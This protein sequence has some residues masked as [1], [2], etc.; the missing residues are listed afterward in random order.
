MNDNVK[1]NGWFGTNKSNSIK[2]SKAFQIKNQKI[3]LIKFE[4][5]CNLQSNFKASD[6]A[7][8][9]FFNKIKCLKKLTVPQIFSVDL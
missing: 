4:Y 7:K 5:Q 2:A 6:K 3:V 1:T 8:I 9:I